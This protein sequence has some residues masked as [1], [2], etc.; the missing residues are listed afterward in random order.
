MRFVEMGTVRRL[1]VLGFVGVLVTGL[2][3]AG[4][5]RKPV[6]QPA[7]LDVEVTGTFTSADLVDPLNRTNCLTVAGVESTFDGCRRDVLPNWPIPDSAEYVR[8]EV[9][10]PYYGRYVLH[11]RNTRNGVVQFSASMHT[12]VGM[13]DALAILDVPRNGRGVIRLRVLGGAAGGGN[14]PALTFER[15]KN[16]FTGPAPGTR[17]H[18]GG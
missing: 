5:L 7:K 11:V 8:F 18:G 4:T 17:R 15:Q 9:K 12:R 13:T 2:I 1:V 3:T 16:V 6:E 14:G 10:Q